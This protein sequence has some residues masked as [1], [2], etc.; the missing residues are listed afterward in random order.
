ME[1]KHAAVVRVPE[2]LDRSSVAA[3]RA[4]LA[5][6]CEEPRASAVVLRGSGGRPFC[7]GVDL[8]V[9]ARGEDPSDAVGAFADCLFAIRSCAKPVICLVEG[10]ADGGGVGIAAAADVVLATADASFALPEL[11]FGLAPAIVLPYLGER[12]A[13]QK[14]RWLAL[15]S[16]RIGASTAMALGLVDRVEPPECCVPAIER[17]VNRLRRAHPDAVAAWKQMTIA[18]PS[19]GSPDGARATLHSLRSSE[20]RDRLRRFVESGDP[21]WAMETS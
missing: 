20:M 8:A 18:P 19:I 12:I 17:W 7:R 14:L 9:L 2:A 5:R 4:A 3:M 6:A 13:R 21:P 16:A 1:L 11:L 10:D 15:E